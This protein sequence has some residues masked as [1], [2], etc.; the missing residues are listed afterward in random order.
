M[1][2]EEKI[3]SNL[4]RH[5]LSRPP[6]RIGTWGWLT[7]YLSGICLL[8]FLLSH[9]AMIHYGTTDAISA[10]RVFLDLRSSF[11]RIIDLGLLGICI[12][13]G[14]S[15]FRRIVLD[16]EWLGKRSD[17]FLIGSLS[18]FGVVM[19]VFGLFIFNGLVSQSF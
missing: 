6:E 12:L 7:L 5:S 10:Q 19:F 2:L 13:H 14:L 4:S 3:E 11:V 18:L 15:G 9:I 17:R 16:L 8:F 1:N